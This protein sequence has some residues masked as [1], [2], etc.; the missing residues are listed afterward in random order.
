MHA[1]AFLTQAVTTTIVQ[2][3]QEENYNMPMTS[4]VSYT[5]KPNTKHAE[6]K[7]HSEKAPIERKLHYQ[8]STYPE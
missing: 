5:R 6:V 4:W 1:D 3:Q 7:P 8:W 2:F